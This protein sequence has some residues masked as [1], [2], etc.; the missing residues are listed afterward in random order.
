[1]AHLAG[2]RMPADHG[3]ASLGLLMQLFGSV[4]AGMMAFYAMMPILA[5]GAQA[6]WVIFVIGAVGCVRSIFHRMAGTSL[7]YGSASGP[8]KL[9]NT[10]VLVAVGQTAI[11]LFLLKKYPLVMDVPEMP[12]KL[13]V[14]LAILLLAWPVALLVIARSPRLRRFESEGVPTA[15]DMG[16]EGAAILMT[17]LGVIGVLFAALV[18]YSLSQAGGKILS[19]P[20]G[21]LTMGVFIML[22]VRAILHV[23]A[24]IKG[25]AGVDS[26]GATDAAAKYY[27]F[28]VV[29]SVITGGVFLVMLMME[30]GG[31]GGAMKFIVVFISIMVYMLLIWPLALRRFFT[32]RNFSALL[33][34]SEAPNYRR[35]PDAGLTALGWLLL[36]TGVYFMAQAL[37][38][39][40]FKIPFDLSAL[41]SMGRSSG[42]EGDLASQLGRSPWWNV[43][44]C[45]A[46]LWA[47]IELITMSDRYR[48]AA[49]AYGAIAT[50]V[51]IYLQW[52]MLKMLKQMGGGGPFAG[53]S[54]TNVLI[55]ALSITLPVATFLLVN[56]NVKPAAQARIRG[57][58][59]G[60]GGSGT[61]IA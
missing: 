17:I 58:E 7:I 1:M 10:Y 44:V 5:G 55:L 20:Q 43:G 49:S 24:G 61:S 51:T 9:I 25:T 42:L 46:Q 52:P 35:A 12:G 18:I 39:A 6:A 48:V 33:S 36:A 26:D 14:T 28:G 57:P 50:V 21:M 30:G 22:L 40:L 19:S 27:N 29:S 16:F 54:A 31:G 8:F 3:L 45:A 4:F 34:G 38:A 13:L 53:D 15:E 56:R 11:T 47:A 23:V 2:A 60:G 41:F 59:V 32:E 37:P